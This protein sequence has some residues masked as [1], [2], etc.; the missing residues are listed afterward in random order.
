VDPVI[1]ISASPN[2]IIRAFY[3]SAKYGMV[4]D[5]SLKQAIRN[6]PELLDK[7]K[8]KYASDKLS[9]AI[10]YNQDIVS[11]LIELGVLQ[12]IKLTKDMTDQLIRSRRLV[13][14]L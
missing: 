11:D 2:R 6:H 7:V 9:A 12:K 8:E 5:D 4:I 3:Y 14:I 10:Q 13:D 1:A